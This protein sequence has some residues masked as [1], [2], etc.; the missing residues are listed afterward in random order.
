M[1]TTRTAASAITATFPS[2]LRK[3]AE[4]GTASNSSAWPN[5]LACSSVRTPCT[6]PCEAWSSS[7]NSARKI[8]ICRRIGRHEAN[9]LVPLSLY[10]F[11]VSWA[12]FSR[13]WPYFFCS[14]L[15]FGWT[16]CSGRLDLLDEERDQRGTD[17]QRQADDRQR[18][19]GAAGRVHE[20]AE[21]IV[22]PTSTTEIAQYS[23]SMMKLPMSPKIPTGQA[24]AGGRVRGGAGRNGVVATGGPR[25]T[26]GEPAY[27]EPARRDRRARAPRRARRRSRRVVATHLAVQRLISAR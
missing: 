7:R 14:S 21:Q 18:P 4:I 17:H 24:P 1:A 9:G 25:V 19:R 16:A 3:V 13:S 11:I 12:S 2:A 5:C 22:E 23:G 8:G 27:G 10:S 26:A 6:L 20:V 15:T